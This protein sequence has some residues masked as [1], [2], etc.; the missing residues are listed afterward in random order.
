MASVYPNA[1]DGY[2]QIR[3]VVDNVDEIIASDHN[4]LRSAIIKIEN[5]L[6]INPSGVFT[7]IKERLDD[8]YFDL[9]TH[10]SGGSP[11]HSDT[12]I[13]SLTKTGSPHISLTGT[14]V[15]A[16]LQEIVNYINNP[17]YLGSSP[18]SFYDGYQLPA[19]YVE[20]A[21][22]EIVRRL[23]STIGANGVGFSGTGSNKFADG[24]ALPIS[25]VSGA[26]TEIIR[27]VGSSNGSSSIGATPFTTI[28]SNY[29][30]SGTDVNSQLQNLGNISNEISN[31]LYMG[32]A[33]SVISDMAVS[34]IDA[35]H[36]SIN[37]GVII[38]SGRFLE[39]GGGTLT[40]SGAGTHKIYA[41]ASSGSVVVQEA[42]TDT[43]FMSSESVPLIEFTEDGNPFTN[44][45]SK[46]FRRFGHF[47]NREN[48]TVGSDLNADFDSLTSAAA[49]IEKSIKYTNNNKTYI[50]YNYTCWRVCN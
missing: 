18:N 8:A 24:Y 27:R 26:I 39:Y 49:W 1:I 9:A 35:T 36:V 30:I 6:G 32:F 29:T 33:P 4:D 23:G 43:E 40:H 28:D 42:S 22:N 3:R 17:E 25:N 48:I 16:Q 14:N 41:K 10:V 21:I 5:E 15:G 45:N 19:S 13:E 47:I 38:V 31:F 12:T 37:S 46:D 11:R 2:N 34:R 20:S 44:L 50:R 7:S